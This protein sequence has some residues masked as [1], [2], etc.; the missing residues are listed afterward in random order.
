[1]NAKKLSALQ[2]RHR[3]QARTKL[4]LL[5]ALVDKLATGERYDSIRIRD[6]CAIADISEASFFNYFPAKE[7]LL[8][9]FVQIW[10]LDVGWY[11]REM[12]AKGNPL[13][14]I[15]EIFMRTAEM[16]EKNPH[17]MAEIIAFQARCSGAIEPAEVG[18]A[19]RLLAHPD[20]PGVDELPAQG[21]DAILPELLA[22]AKRSGQIPAEVDEQF[23]YVTLLSIFFGAPVV[24]RRC[25]P[26]TLRAMWKAQ[27]A[28]IWRSIGGKQPDG[29]E[30]NR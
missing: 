7:A 10:S 2:H 11:A 26:E 17:I 25:G 18:I 19:E 22:E 16:V 24:L 3:K 1:M 23:V 13:G 12:L 30:G 27:L 14:A 29:E 28:F 6:L 9:Y 8:V 5:A 4:A 21:L 15:E 20:L